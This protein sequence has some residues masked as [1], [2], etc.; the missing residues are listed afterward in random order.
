[1]YGG[2]ALNTLIQDAEKKLEIDNK[3]YTDLSCLSPILKRY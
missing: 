1:M 3:M 2:K